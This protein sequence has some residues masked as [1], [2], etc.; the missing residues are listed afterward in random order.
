MVSL[1]DNNH[2]FKLKAAQ[3]QVQAIALTTPLDEEVLVNLKV[4]NIVKISGTIYTGRDVAH[5]LMTEA[6]TKNSLS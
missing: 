3:G 4:G 1:K 2:Y 5:K 6:L